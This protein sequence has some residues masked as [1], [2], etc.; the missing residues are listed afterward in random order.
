M[1]NT[2]DKALLNSILIEFQK[3]DKKHAY[4]KLKEYINTYTKDSLAIYNY[5]YI[6]QHFNLTDIAIENFKNSNCLFYTLGNYGQLLRYALEMN[7]INN[8]DLK[9][10]NNWREDPANWNKS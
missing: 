6:S 8:D 5:A 10:L 7:Y 9:L 2:F 1:S 3:G 4:T